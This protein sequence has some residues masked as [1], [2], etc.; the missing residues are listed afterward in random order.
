MTVCENNLQLKTPRL[1]PFPLSTTASESVGNRE[2]HY[3]GYL[4]GLTN[5]DMY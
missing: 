5:S 2:L 3:I 4:E 1:L